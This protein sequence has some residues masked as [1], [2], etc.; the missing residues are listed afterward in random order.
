MGTLNWPTLQ[1]RAL[2]S[3]T[4]SFKTCN[5]TNRYDLACRKQEEGE[6]FDQYLVALKSLA[7]DAELCERC[8]DTQVTTLVINGVRNHDARRK[9][10]A[11]KKF[12]SLAEATD[13][14]RAEEGA[15]KTSSSDENKI[16]VTKVPFWYILLIYRYFL[17]GYSKKT[18]KFSITN[19]A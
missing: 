5:V 7:D 2:K 10:L 4:K 3:P 15:A 6:S 16:S 18:Y 12:P 17:K 9:L 14:C 8:S 13:V 19:R 11:L 1:C